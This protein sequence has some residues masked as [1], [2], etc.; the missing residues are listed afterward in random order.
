MELRF[1][2]PCCDVTTI[3]YGGK[4]ILRYIVSHED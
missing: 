1:T 3:V 4:D 2:H